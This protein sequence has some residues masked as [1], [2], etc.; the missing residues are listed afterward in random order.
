M[1][2]NRLSWNMDAKIMEKTLIWSIGALCIVASVLAIR[3]N[4]LAFLAL[5]VLPLGAI[6][7]IFDF[8][9]L[10]FLLFASIP[11]SVEIYLPGSLATDLPT[12]PLMWVLM[13]VSLVYF[14][15]NIKHLDIRPLRH[16]LTIIL[17]FHLSWIYATMI[18]SENFL[19]SLK[20]SLAKIWYIAVFYFL[21]T[22]IIKED[23]LNIKKVV[24]PTFFTLVIVMLICLVRH[25]AIGF[26]FTEVN[27]IVGPF[28]Q[29]H[30]IYAALPATFIPFAWYA[31]Y[32]E[33][34]W[35]F[36]WILMALGIVV[37][38]LGVQFSYTRTVY[39]ALVMAIG[40]YYVIR[41]R[42]MK[43]VLAVVSIATIAFCL[44]IVRHNRFLDYAPDFSKTI[45]HQ[46]F[47][48]LL[49]A[50]YKMQDISTMERV[51]RWVAAGHMIAD[52]PWMGFGPGTFYS[53]YKKYTVNSF[54][55]YVSDNP[56]RSSTH[57]YFLM[58]WVEQ[59][60]FGLLFFMLFNFGALLLGER[61]YHQAKNIAMRRI[62]LMATLSLVIIN[63][64]IIINDMIE[65]DKTGSFFFFC[66]AVLVSL[67]IK[68]Q[69]KET[70]ISLE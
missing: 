47:D 1:L 3:Y 38:L 14:L 46:S 36:K 16:P 67:D 33:K 60:I 64:I 31:M 24:Y 26:S 9:K 70:S 69:E 29:N 15:L 5:P 23:Y 63:A 66:A 2:N 68:N 17:L 7:A 21:T 43:W 4:S 37:L 19:F 34:R 62:G 11:F 20:Y 39:V 59:G 51:Y 52:K 12:E 61:V 57:C 55:T 48:N 53:F 42:L 10:Y 50:T 6:V 18:S 8:K 25:A 28:F 40:A 32:W 41:W 49:D 58:V 35:S 30:V 45:S 54:R 27:H 13:G 22:K 44:Y 65:T 56:E